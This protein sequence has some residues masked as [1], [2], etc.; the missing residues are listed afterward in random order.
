MKRLFI[1]ISVLIILI[2]GTMWALSGNPEYDPAVVKKIKLASKI[3]KLKPVA[4]SGDMEAQYQL[5]SYYENGQGVAPDKGVAAYWYKKAA[6]QGHVPAQFSLGKI[7]ESGEGLKQDFF[8]ASKWYRLAASFGN[9]RDA[10]FNLAQMYFKG[11]GVD[12]DYGKAI[13]FYRQAA[14]QGHPVAQFILG[15]MYEEGWGVTQDYIVAYMW[16][17]MAE[18]KAEETIAANRNYNPIKALEK[19]KSKM[20]RYQIEEAE[21]R[22]LKNAKKP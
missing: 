20:N 6:E 3:K 11:R 14:S 1:A 2:G 5:G 16:Y 8:A 21:K 12:H 22:I 17:K 19:I 15:A 9:H 4:E 10:Q 7:Y 13:T 18:T